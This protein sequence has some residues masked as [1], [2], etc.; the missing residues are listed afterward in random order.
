VSPYLLQPGK[1]APWVS[2]FKQILETSLGA[3][4]ETPTESH[5]QISQLNKSPCWQLKGIVAQITL[6]LFQK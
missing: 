2:L 4:Y 5:Q 1:V 6:K 3:E